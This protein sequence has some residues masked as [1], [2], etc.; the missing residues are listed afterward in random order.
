MKKQM[1]EFDEI[2]DENGLEMLL[3]M[4]EIIK[5]QQIIAID[6]TKLIL[7]HAKPEKVTKESIF[8]IFRDATNVVSEQLDK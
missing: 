7:E 6:L 3:T 2:L 8:N 4:A 5:G 1:H